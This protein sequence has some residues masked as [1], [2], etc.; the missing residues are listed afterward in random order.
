MCLGY[1]EKG[2]EVGTLLKE[3][4]RYGRIILRIILGR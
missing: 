2:S 1:G 4:E 3:R